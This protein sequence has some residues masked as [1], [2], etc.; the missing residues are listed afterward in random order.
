VWLVWLVARRLGSTTL[1]AA[2]S[3][4]FFAINMAAFG[5]FWKPMYVFDLLCATFSLASLLAY[6]AHR[7]V[8]SFIAFWLALKCK[9]LAVMLPVVLGCYEYWFGNRQWKRLIPFVA[10]SAV[11]GIRGLLSTPPDGHEY[12]FQFNAAAIWKTSSF[13]ASKVLLWRYAGFLLIPLALLIKDARLRF[14]LAMLV[15]FLFP[16]LFLPGRM[17]AAYTYLPSI[18][19]ALA[20]SAFATRRYAMPLTVFLVTW[21]LRDLRE[22]RIERRGALALAVNTKQ[23]VSTLQEFVRRQADSDPVFIVD[24]LPPGF[25]EWGVSGALSRFM[26]PN[27]PRVYLRNRWEGQ[28]ALAEQGAT[29]LKWSEPANKLLIA[30]RADIKKT[31]SYISFSDG[32]VV[33]HLEKGWYTPEG[34]YCWI[35][36]Y[37]TAR[38]NRP[39]A[40]Q[41]FE[42]TVNA[43]PELIGKIGGSHVTVFLDGKAIGDHWF[44]SP[45]WEQAHWQVP[46]D[47]D[48]G[49]VEVA[50]VV[51]PEF[52]PPHDSR[53]L[54]IAVGA[55]GFAER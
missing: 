53:T 13:Y 14:G 18:G 52:H 25:R 10:V 30:T 5:V 23:Y 46:P 8:L 19:L 21:T 47:P 15:L 38:L 27:V 6:G 4:A 49:E 55:F 3:A 28:A 43:G 54:G 35:A 42:L 50:F 40:C 22:L 11:F 45:G 34:K 7:L 12:A 9:E 1:A 32:G 41:R 51:K 29:L 26:R 16:L 2:L 31:P 44:G 48:G 24:G 20:M 39:A 17:F 36:P 37:A 33:W